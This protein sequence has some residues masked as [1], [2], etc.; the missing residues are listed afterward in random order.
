MPTKDYDAAATRT[1]ETIDTSPT[2]HPTNKRLIREFHRDLLLDGISAARRQKVTAH[3]NIVAEHIGQNRFDRLERRDITDLIE[4]IH[5]RDIMSSTVSDYKQIIKQF[6][7][8]QN[9][10]EEPEQTAW[11]RRDAA[12]YH[13]ILPRHLLTPQDISRLIDA[14]VNDRDRAFIALLWETGARIGEVIDLRYGDIED[15]SIGKRVVVM[16]KT[17][18]R[19]LPLIESSPYI[20]QWLMTH[21]APG[22]EAPLWCKIEQ[23]TSDDQ[24]GYNYIRLRLLMR[25]QKRA[26][27]EKPV[28]PHHF[29][30]SRATHLANW[31][32]EAQLCEWFG[33]VQGSKIPARYVHL[34]GR[35]IDNAYRALFD[36]QAYNS[37][38]QPNRR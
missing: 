14:C 34:S 9:N 1:L 15:D 26:D 4:W 12:S 23:G 16:G 21:P 27:I 30:H 17:G 3:L 2:I 32:T 35:D 7:K 20:V 19:R 37:L 36:E 5:N 13:H 31:L 22:T 10:G 8:W 6:Y 28:N 25:A 29:R 24:I 11:I 18:S 38:P 33:W